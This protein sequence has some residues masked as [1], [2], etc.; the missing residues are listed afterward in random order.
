MLILF[1]PEE[2]NIVLGFYRETK[3]LSDFD[4]NLADETDL[5]SS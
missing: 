4:S 2:K 1:I 3:L 5:H